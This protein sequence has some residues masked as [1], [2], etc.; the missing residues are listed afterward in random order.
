[1]ID[2]GVIIPANQPDLSWNETTGEWNGIIIQINYFEGQNSIDNPVSDGDILVDQ[3]PYV[4]KVTQSEYIN[5][6]KFRI[7]IQLL[8][9][10]PSI[11]IYPSNSTMRGLISTPN[12][13]GF[14]RPHW[15][16]TKVSDV[17]Y[18]L[19]MIYNFHMN[20]KFEKLIMDVPDMSDPMGLH[21]VTVNFNENG[22]INLGGTYRLPTGSDMKVDINPGTGFSLDAIVLDG[23]VLETVDN[24]YIIQNVRENHAVELVFTPEV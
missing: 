11:N 20:E 12:K 21:T 15:N 1:M 8:N 18:K 24:P 2:G 6:D 16:G 13:F 5:G 9:K 22:T 14:I 19:A 7:N 4:W 23:T 10:S 3:S 17:C